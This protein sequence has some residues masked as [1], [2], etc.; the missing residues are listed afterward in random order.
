LTAA[1]WGLWSLVAVR[2]LFG[3][4]EAGAYPNAARV[5]TRWFPPHE[6]GRAPG[7]LLAAGLVGGSASP[8]LVADLI[9]AFGWRSVFI[10]FG[11]VGIVWAVAFAIW[12]RDSPADHPAVNDAER[13]LIGADPA[14]QV[15]LAVPWGRVL[16]HPSIWLLGAAVSCN[17]FVTYVY[18]S[19]YPK[20][21]QKGRNVADIES[22]WLAAL[23]LCGGFVG[24]VG[25]GLLRD[26][27]ARR[28][29]P[30]SV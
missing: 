1:C 11:L 6:R 19:W 17:A 20:Y 7:L 24:M 27:F 29:A 28:A 8:A 9:Q 14:A 18:F 4:G 26:W 15:H 21:L 12:F 10:V 3:A 16:R 22:G 23:V 30:L 2:F 13:G 5:I 25:G